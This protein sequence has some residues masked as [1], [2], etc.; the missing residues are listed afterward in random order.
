MENQKITA[1]VLPTRDRTAISV[2]FRSG[3]PIGVESLIEAMR[4]FSA[5]IEANAMKPKIASIDKRIITP[6]D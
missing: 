2:L 1:D 3:D 4:T 5:Q 6:G